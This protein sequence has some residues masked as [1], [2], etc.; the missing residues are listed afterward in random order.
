MHVG[1]L[2]FAPICPLQSMHPA[3]AT[4]CGVGGA[5]AQRL[6]LMKSSG[7]EKPLPSRPLNRIALSKCKIKCRQQWPQPARSWGF[8]ASDL[9]EEQRLSIAPC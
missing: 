5:I 4:I 6:R 9:E 8:G 2:G 1:W 3:D 7:G